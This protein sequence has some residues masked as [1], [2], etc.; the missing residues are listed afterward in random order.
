VSDKLSTIEKWF[1]FSTQTSSV[2]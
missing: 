2:K 1:N